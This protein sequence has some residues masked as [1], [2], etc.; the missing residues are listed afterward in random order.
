MVC[1]TE[2]IGSWPVLLIMEPRVDGEASDYHSDAGFIGDL[3]K[4]GAETNEGD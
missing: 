4:F 2:A 1:D 3:S